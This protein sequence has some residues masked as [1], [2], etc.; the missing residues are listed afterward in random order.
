MGESVSEERRP[1]AASPE[2]RRRAFRGF[3]WLSAANAS[4][5]VLRIL[6][7]AVLARLVLPS[8]F[9]LLA[10]AG[11][12]L[13]FLNIFSGVG[14]GPALV[15][16]T[17]LDERHIRTALTTSAGFGVVLGF[18][19]FASADF[20]AGLFEIVGLVPVLRVMAFAIPIAALS[21]VN[22]A[23]LQRELRFGAIAAAELIS[24]VVGYGMVGTISAAFGAGVWALVSAEMVKSIVK[25]VLL[26]RASPAVKRPGFDRRA[27]RE[28]I[29]FGAGYTASSLSIYFA[30]EG[31]NLV[32]AR[33]LGS[34]ALGVYG[35]AYELMLVPAKALGEI[36]DKVMFAA[37]SRVQGDQQ[38]LGVAYRRGIAVMAL[39]VLPASATTLILAPEIV[40]VLLGTRW[41]SVVAPLRILALA[42]Y[43]QMG[44]MV[45]QSV[46]NA[47]GAVLHTAWRSGVYAV[48]VV[49]GALVGQ[50]AGLPGVAA[51]VALAIT[52][53]FVLTS[54]LAMRIT[55]T[56]VGGFGARHGPA[57]MFTAVAGVT[58]WVVATGLRRL[59]AAPP[60][61]LAGSILSATASSA[62]LL[63]AAPAGMLGQDVVWIAQALRS[64]TPRPLRPFF[65]WALGSH[66]VE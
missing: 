61:V 6:V 10:A 62:L 4:R 59:G 20:V 40:Q 43:F 1:E 8:D 35:R 42:M 56:A 60:V 17:E 29:T 23:L 48:L 2:F 63:R 5:G 30:L 34:A 26:W 46:A 47:S 45:G 37:L 24:Y 18:G 28:L 14:V 19:A 53:N 49:L 36:L 11:S 31:D 52:V 38:Q 7:L 41:M 16:R 15:Q 21:S 55:G 25:A 64:K 27:F 39:L 65:F 9:G 13:W 50:R 57:L 22:E 32:I 66:P 3:A 54:Q 51:G 44:Y 33:S 12:V 58:M